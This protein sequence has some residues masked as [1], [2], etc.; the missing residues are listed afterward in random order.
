MK[1]TAVTIFLP[2]SC[3]CWMKPLFS[4]YFWFLCFSWLLISFFNFSFFPNSCLCWS[5]AAP[6]WTLSCLICSKAFCRSFSI[7]SYSLFKPANYCCALWAYLCAWSLFCC[8]KR[9]KFSVL[10]IL[11]SVSWS[12]YCSLSLWTSNCSISALSWTISLSI[13]WIRW[14]KSYISSL[15]ALISRYIFLIPFCI[16]SIWR[17]ISAILF[18]ISCSLTLIS[19]ICSS[20][21]CFCYNNCS[22]CSCS[23]Y[24][25]SSFWSI[26]CLSSSIF[27]LISVILVWS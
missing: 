26:Y 2:I 16:C 18:L 3:I 17:L 9:I 13:S 4:F 8:F 7:F 25:K 12:C 6:C 10:L 5:K 15:I 19:A 20:I 23:L 11:A 24:I 1:L 27:L 22:S 14:L 21:C